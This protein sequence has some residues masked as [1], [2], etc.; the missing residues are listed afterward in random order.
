MIAS[1]FIKAIA[2]SASI[3][4]G[5]VMAGEINLQH[6]SYE[7][8]MLFSKIPG[9]VLYIDSY[10]CVTGNIELTLQASTTSLFSYNSFKYVFSSLRTMWMDV[11]GG[12]ECRKGDVRARAFLHDELIS[13]YIST[14]EYIDGNVSFTM[15][16]NFLE[17]PIDTE[18]KAINTFYYLISDPKPNN[19][20]IY[21]YQAHLMNKMPVRAF[22]DNR[23]EALKEFLLNTEISE[24][25]LRILDR[26]F[27]IFPSQTEIEND[28]SLS[29]ALCEVGAFEYCSRGWKDAYEDLYRSTSQGLYLK[30]STIASIVRMTIGEEEKDFFSAWRMD[31]FKSSYP[32]VAELVVSG[33]FADL[34]NIT[35]KAPGS[36]AI[37]MALNRWMASYCTDRRPSLSDHRSCPSAWC[38]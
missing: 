38:N 3:M 14:D 30:D 31:I 27:K 15:D 32:Q 13:D 25:N 36:G 26:Y 11:G 21:S 5:S 19:K 8:P 4:S 7:G 12:Y 29:I 28:P 1:K 9:A 2:L 24:N 35:A 34:S 16:V 22:N 18:E 10:D 20:E 33:N 6:K 17:H 23:A 37:S